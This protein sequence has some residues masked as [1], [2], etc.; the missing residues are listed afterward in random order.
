MVLFQEPGCVAPLIGV[1][2]TRVKSY[3]GQ[4]RS[5]EKC[6]S[7]KPRTQIRAVACQQQPHE[8][9]RGAERNKLPETF[10]PNR[11]C[12]KGARERSCDGSHC[13]LRIC[14]LNA[15]ERIGW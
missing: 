2:R 10:G 7:E 8:Q 14:Q 13:D 1:S 3:S 5:S 4:E 6:R 9:G 15:R 11:V 12:R